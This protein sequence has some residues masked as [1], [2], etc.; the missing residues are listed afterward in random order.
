MG[1][2]FAHSC[3]YFV[4]PVGVFYFFFQR[5]MKSSCLLYVRHEI[6]KEQSLRLVAAESADARQLPAL[7]GFH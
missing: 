5:V 1:D 3:L 4:E 2:N 6:G 7:E